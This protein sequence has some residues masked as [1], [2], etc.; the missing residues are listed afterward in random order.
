MDGALA[1]RTGM[2]VTHGLDNGQ[3]QI[4]ELQMMFQSNNSENVVTL[5]TRIPT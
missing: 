1:I 2:N 3:Q 5:P 4:L